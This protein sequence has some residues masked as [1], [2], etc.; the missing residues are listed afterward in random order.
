MCI[1]HVLPATILELLSTKRIDHCPKREEVN[2]STETYHER[3]GTVTERKHQSHTANQRWYIYYMYIYNMMV[4]IHCNTSTDDDGPTHTDTHT[5]LTFNEWTPIS[6]NDTLQVQNFFFQDSYVHT[7][8]G[9]S[10]PCLYKSLQFLHFWGNYLFDRAPNNWAPITMSWFRW[11][12]L[13][14]PDKP[15]VP[16]NTC[17]WWTSGDSF[18]GKPLIGQDLHQKIPYISWE[19]PVGRIL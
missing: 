16:P 8:L 12:K 1:N 18:V 15:V 17:C 11:A 4:Y 3:T 5:P 2:T 13:A 7:Y 19:K 9:F 14:S 6:Y 10:I